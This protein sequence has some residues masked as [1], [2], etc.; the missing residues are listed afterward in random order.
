MGGDQP[1]PDPAD[2]DHDHRHQREPLGALER[3]DQPH[4]HERDRV[5]DQVLP[6]RVDER[7]GEDAPQV[8]DVPGVDA[9]AVE[10]VRV[11]RVDRLDHPHQHDHPRQ[12]RDAL[13]LRL[14]LARTGGGRRGRWLGTVV[15]TRL[16]RIAGGCT[17]DEAPA[18]NRAP[19]PRPPAPPPRARAATARARTPRGCGRRRR[20]GR[21]RRRSA[22]YAAR[23]GWRRWRRR[24]GSR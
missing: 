10:V 5:R 9:V 13:E 17:G 15:L 23:S 20:G 3:D 6:A 24:A 2:H 14:T 7:R 22:E 1:R 18:K 21:G 12:Q 4:E 11:E 8:V 19:R 16:S